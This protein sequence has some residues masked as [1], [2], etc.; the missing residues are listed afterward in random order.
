MAVNPYALAGT[1]QSFMDSLMKM[2][3]LEK[4]QQFQTG[5]HKEKMSHEFQRELAQNQADVES[6][7]N[8]KRKKSFLEQALPVL[9]MAM[10]PLA[11][12]ALSGGLA[13]RGQ[14]KSAGFAEKQAR[15]AKAASRMDPKWANTFLK[16]RQTSY[17]T[18]TGGQLNEMIRQAKEAGSGGN[19]MKTGLAS[20]L[21]S[22]AMSKAAGGKAGEG[23][24]KE[25]FFKNMLTKDAKGEGGFSD[26][27]TDAL[28][29]GT[30]G[31]GDG[32]QG[33]FLTHLLSLF[34]N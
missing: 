26:F 1:Q 5:E 10:N 21:G 23:L 24:F 4:E 16:E 19:L 15:S 25:D 3:G 8:K 14:K 9:T 22:F 33:A 31:E 30:D 17:E 7:L 34:G 12:A 32:E 27:L 29:F 13:A 28:G 11:G 2:K 20:G 6:E 18:E